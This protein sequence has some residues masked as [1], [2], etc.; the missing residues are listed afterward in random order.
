MGYSNRC[1]HT[2]VRFVL[3]AR[4]MTL[5]E[6][7][8][9]EAV[10]KLV[11]DISDLI[12]EFQQERGCS[13]VYLVSGGRQ[14]GDKVAEQAAKATALEARVRSGFDAV[15]RLSA[16]SALFAQVNCVLKDFACLPGMR[17][18]I[19]AVNVAAP[20][21]F[22]FFSDMIADLLAVVSA[23]TDITNDSDVARSLISYF[24]F[25]HAKELAG[26]ERGLA[27]ACFAVGRFDSAKHRRFLHLIAAQKHSLKIF[28]EYSTPEQTSA[29]GRH[30]DIPAVAEIERMRRVVR[31]GGL[32][33][34]L[35]NIQSTH[36]FD[37]TTQ[38]INAMKQVEDFLAKDL[39][40]LCGARVAEAGRAFAERVPQATPLLALSAHVTRLCLRLSAWWFSRVAASMRGEA[41]GRPDEARNPWSVEALRLFRQG[42]GGGGGLAAQQHEELRRRESRHEFIEDATHEFNVSGVSAL[43]AIGEVANR[44][45]ERAEAMSAIAS[46]TNRR[47]LDMAIV[48]QQSTS[49][50]Q[51]VA[52][53]ADKLSGSIAEINTQAEESLAMASGAVQEAE[54]THDAATNLA[55]AANRIAEV[56]ELISVIAA[57]TNL[58]ALNATIEAARAGEAGKGFA[59]VAGEVKTLAGQTAKATEDIG[60]HVEDIQAVAGAVIHAIGSIRSSVGRMDGIVGRV[61]QAL[62]E[63]KAATDHIT[64]NIEQMASGSERVSRSVDGVTEAAGHT[65]AMAT[66]VLAAAQELSTLAGTMRGGLDVFIAKVSAE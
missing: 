47:S 63:Q 23:A 51:A 22:A 17:D 16:G 55:G 37:Q 1:S 2:A 43:G 53:A 39:R 64:H 33:G 62:V 21:A 8:H 42:R 56:G 60:R 20:E 36:W 24:N 31:S 11:T 5:C 44:M 28:D 13:N 18:S 3:A 27:T 30:M 54:R 46:D 45:Q 32:T 57:Q 59:V 4:F 41:L 38:R 19:R 12:H 15:D 10:I 61:V 50:A 66:N 14:F 52:V 65:G 6:L 29:A 58:L 34:E 9:L 48:M 40:R 49:A 35:E 7:K 26:Q 25:M